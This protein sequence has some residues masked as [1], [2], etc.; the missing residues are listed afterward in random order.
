MPKEYDSSPD[1]FINNS[2]LNDVVRINS[3]HD[4][5]NQVSSFGKSYD[6]FFHPDINC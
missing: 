4:N 5:N 3:V 2:N 1:R 6:Y